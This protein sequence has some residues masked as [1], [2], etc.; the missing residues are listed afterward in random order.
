[1]R[2]MDY[3]LN[4]EYLYS[5]N[6]YSLVDDSTE[7]LLCSRRIAAPVMMNISRGTNLILRRLE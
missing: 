2:Q 4:A 1:M 7:Q 6:Q 3:D 5:L